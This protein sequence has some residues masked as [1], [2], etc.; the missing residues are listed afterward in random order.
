MMI[1]ICEGND[2]EKLDW[3]K[4]INIAGEQLANQ[5]LR[6][7]MY[8]GRWLYETKRN[9]SEMRKKISDGANAG[10]SH[11]SVEQGRKNNSGKLPDALRRMQPTEK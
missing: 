11:H 1:Y 3:F 10:G 4:T 6:N 2:R 9:L 7:A 8:T 5:E